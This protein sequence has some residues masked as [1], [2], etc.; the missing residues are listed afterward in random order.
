MRNRL[1]L[2]GFLLTIISI[3]ETQA[4]F[5]RSR[6]SAN[7]GASFFASDSGQGLRADYSKYLSSTFLINPAIFY[8]WGTP[9]QSEYNHIGADVLIGVIPFYL[10]NKFNLSVRAGLTGG[11]EKLT[12]LERDVTGFSVGGKGGGELEF[13]VSESLSL[14]AY[15]YQAYLLKKVF[16]SSY[17]HL[18]LGIKINIYNY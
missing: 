12:G 10:G 15:A 8:E 1:F 16:G 13:M 11:Y 7:I 6:G 14:S 5:M 3:N 4:Q 17:Y 9:M 18:G 2:I